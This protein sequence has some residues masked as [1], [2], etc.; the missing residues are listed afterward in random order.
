MSCSRGRAPF[1]IIFATFTF[2]RSGTTAL[3]AQAL[4]RND[5]L[6]ERAV[7]WRAFVIAAI[8]GLALV[9][10]SP[11]I[12][13]VGEWLMNRTAC[14]GRDGSLHPHPPYCGACLPH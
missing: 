3:V 4:G 6:E 11:L 1:D 12:A 13:A 10:F 7:F 14:D 8:S 2:L 5:A 9:L